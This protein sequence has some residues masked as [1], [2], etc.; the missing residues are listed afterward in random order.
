MDRAEDDAF[1]D[2]ALIIMEL[3]LIIYGTYCLSTIKSVIFKILLIII[4]F[5]VIYIV[6][7]FI[8]NY[9]DT[10]F[11]TSTEL[12]SSL[13]VISIITLSAAGAFWSI[14][15]N[16][17]IF[18]IFIWIIHFGNLFI[19]FITL[20]DMNIIPD[21]D[22]N[23][24]LLIIILTSGLISYFIPNLAITYGIQTFNKV[25]AGLLTISLAAYIAYKHH[26]AKEMK[27]KDYEDKKRQL[28]SRMDRLTGR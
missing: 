19:L 20:S 25:A 8:N 24:E 28:I 9:F 21:F 12:L 16:L 14:T 11:E 18:D 2:L 6:L 4:V 7:L 13:V 1:Y 3:L 22:P 15:V 5:L 17:G 27:R 23:N 10:Y 26:R